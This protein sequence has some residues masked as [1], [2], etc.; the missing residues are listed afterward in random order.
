MVR[1]VRVPPQQSPPTFPLSRL[2]AMLVTVTNSP[3]LRPANGLGSVI[4]PRPLAEIQLF[5]LPYNPSFKLTAR[6]K[7]MPKMGPRSLL[8][9]G[10]V[11]SEAKARLLGG[12]ALTAGSL[13]C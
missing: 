6:W 2:H 3:K 9:N 8:V 10:I 5:A 12:A 1:S 4:T 7:G 11:P 13:N